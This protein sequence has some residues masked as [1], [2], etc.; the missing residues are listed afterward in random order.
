MFCPGLVFCR[1]RCVHLLIVPLMCFIAFPSFLLPLDPSRPSRNSAIVFHPF[2]PLNLLG[3]T[4]FFF[5]H[6]DT[7]LLN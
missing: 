7:S 4:P 5:Q 6:C 2:C 1:L 3:L